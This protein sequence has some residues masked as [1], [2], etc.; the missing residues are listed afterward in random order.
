MAPTPKNYFKQYPF[1]DRN[2]YIQ[3]FK[4]AVK[5]I[6]QKEFN[7]LVYYG[8]AGIGKTSLR[9][10]LS[11]YLEEYCKHSDKKVIWASI[12]L[13]LDKHREKTPFLV[14][15]KNDLQRKSK[16]KFP[17]FEIAHA[18]Y[19]K[20]AYPEIP[21]RKE[22]YLFFEGDDAFDDFYGVVEKIPYFSLVPAVGKL[23]KNAPDYLRA[24]LKII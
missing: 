13:Q 12:D 5:N 22:N 23:L 19:W 20:K 11:K 15:L 10:E 6:G 21:L 17:A 4:E 14:T 7:V 18:I 3:T 16:I 2:C 1:V 8:V 24:C 9:K